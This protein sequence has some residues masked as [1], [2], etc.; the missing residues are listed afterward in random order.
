MPLLLSEAAACGLGVE[1]G[2][3][4]LRAIGKELLTCAGGFLESNVVMAASKSSSNK[5]P[6]SCSKSKVDSNS[7]SLNGEADRGDES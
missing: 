1:T 7:G 2:V 5:L 3:E 6:N 4:V